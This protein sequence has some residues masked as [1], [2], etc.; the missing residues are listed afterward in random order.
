MYINR[1][2]N[3]IK[4][5]SKYSKWF[6]YHDLEIYTYSELD[7]FWI[8]VIVLVMFFQKLSMIH[9]EFNP[10]QKVNQI[11]K[12]IHRDLVRSVKGNFIFEEN[13]ELTT[14]VY[15]VYITFKL[16]I[17]IFYYYKAQT[18]QVMREKISTTLRTLHFLNIID[19]KLLFIPVCIMNWQNIIN[20]AIYL[21]ILSLAI[22]IVQ[23]CLIFI[24]TNL[25]FDFK[26]EKTALNQGRTVTRKFIEFIGFFIMSIFYVALKDQGNQGQIFLK[27]MNCIMSLAQV[28]DYHTSL[29]FIAKPYIRYLNMLCILTYIAES[30]IGLIY[31][32]IP[33]L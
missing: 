14:I 5:W 13:Y 2:T 31:Q 26:F 8:T 11:H 32:V 21:K 23:A 7:Y 17:F 4:F 22:I 12:W 18:I 33:Q 16:G 24:E 19:L 28:Y 27:V 25:N 1:D 3:N 29:H 10:M 9:L 6:I 30:F 15:T 20:H